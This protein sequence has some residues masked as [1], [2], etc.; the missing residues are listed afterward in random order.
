MDYKKGERVKH[1]TR[2]DWGLGEVLQDS[3]S[4]KVKIFFTEEGEKTFSLKYI[5]L[6]K[7]EGEEAKHPI[8][9]NLSV[10]NSSNRIKYQSLSQSINNFLQL[11]PNGFCGE[12]YHKVQR[13]HKVKAHQLASELLNLK[14]FEKLLNELNYDE[15]CKRALK[16]ANATNL[17]FPKE[18]KSLKDGLSTTTGKKHFSESLYQLLYGTSNLA[19]RFNDFSNVLK[20]IGTAK[21]TTISYFLFIVFPEK[22]MFVKPKVTKDAAEIS[23]FEINYDPE[24]NWFTY[25]SILTFSEYLKKELS[26][27]KLRDMIDV[28]SFMWCIAESR[29]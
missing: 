2:V 27:L 6:I 13:N 25:N 26:E 3:H 18:K 22:Y 14:D 23:A 15:I 12:K 28:Q 17:V 29:N 8:L 21:W 4:D 5:Q 9:D 20:D 16:V 7:V 1:P 19:Q 24:L 10:S 11:Y